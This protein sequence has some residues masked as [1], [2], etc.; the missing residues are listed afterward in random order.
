MGPG[1]ESTALKTLPIPSGSMMSCWAGI[2]ESS[3]SVLFKT[4]VLSLRVPK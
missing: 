2:V 3:D 4:W 1:E